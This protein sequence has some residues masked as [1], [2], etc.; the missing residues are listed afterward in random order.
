MPNNVSR[1]TFHKTKIHLN[2][3]LRRVYFLL[4]HV[5]H[6]MDRKILAVNLSK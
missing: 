2:A 4:F 6:Q 1:E 3:I 5:K